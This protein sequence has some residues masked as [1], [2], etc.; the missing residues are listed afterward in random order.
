VRHESGLLRVM[1]LVGTRPEIIR[2]CKVIPLLDKFCEH[3]F[4]Y[5]GQ[6]DDPKLRDVFFRELSLRNPDIELR[7]KRDSSHAQI[8]AVI[9]EVGNVLA[10]ERPDRVLILGDTDSALGAIPAARMGIPV[11]HLEAGNR[12][13]DNRV[14][15][16]TNR[17]LI[18]QV[19]TVLLPY[20]E[21]SK[22]NLIREGFARDR[23]FVVGNPIGEVLAQIVPAGGNHP[24]V[25]KSLGVDGPYALLSLHRAENVDDP[26][27][28][29]RI[30]SGCAQVAK[31]VGGSVIFSVHPRTRKRLEALSRNA[32]DLDD[33]VL[34]GPFG[35]RAFVALQLS[36]ELIL[37]DSGT[38]QEEAAILGRPSVVLRDATERAE[39]LEAGTTLLSGSDPDLIVACSQIAL[40]MGTDWSLPSGYAPGPVS[41][42]IVKIVLS[43][44]PGSVASLG[45]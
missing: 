16:E 36:A 32:V 10:S 17:R 41:S 43:R 3:T 45:D 21:R 1:T 12:C 38:V 8:A 28:L 42:T 22:E 9:G 2:L 34:C 25:A 4:V 14:P 6:N 20:T 19:S 18:D 35:L 37:T 44:I 31:L 26:E 27:R 29:V 33:F 5:T 39:T 13:Y 30:L 7:V 40:Q 24:S 15:E 23:I 11:F